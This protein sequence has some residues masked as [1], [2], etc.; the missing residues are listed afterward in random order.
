MAQQNG[1]NEEQ[2][3]FNEEGSKVYLSVYNRIP[4]VL[5][6]EESG[7]DATEVFEE[8]RE[9]CMYYKIYKKGKE[10]NVEGTN[11]DYVPARLRYKM[12]ATLINKEARFLF[13]EQP[14][15]TIE[16]KGDLEEFTEDT[17]RA[18]TIMNELVKTIL[19]KN[20]FQDILIKGAR[21]CFIGKRV[22]CLINFNEKDG[23]TLTFLPSTQF[24][25]EVRSTNH[26]VL[27]KF[28][29]F[30]V[31]KDSKTNSIK[32]IFKKKYTLENINGIDK[33]FL[34][35]EIYD[36]TAK[37][38]EKVMPKT[39]MIIDFIPAVI[40]INDGLS[41]E[42][43]GESEIESLMDFEEWYSKLGNADADAERKSMNPTKYL[44]DMANNSTKNLSTAA[45]ALWDLGSDQNLENKH[46]EVGL[47]EPQMHYSEALKTTLDRIKT[48]GYE[49]VDMPNITN[50]SLSGVI[51][52]GKALKAI[53]WPLIVRCKEK[54]KMWGP[55][56]SLMVEMIVKGAMVYPNTIKKYTN[57]ILVP[58]DHTV[59]VVQNTPLPEDE[60]E[61]KTIDLAEVEANTMSKKAYMKKWRGLTNSQV[62][63]E[64]N[65]I[66][67][68]RQI[69]EDASFSGTTSNGMNGDN[70]L[71]NGLNRDEFISAGKNA[72][73]RDGTQKQGSENNID[74]KNQMQQT[75]STMSKLNGTQIGSLISILGGYKA[76]N[77]TKGQAKHLIMSMGLDDT[78]AEALLEEEKLEVTPN[79]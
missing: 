46:V 37:L 11:G 32:R 45:G 59:E 6:R 9:I 76:G 8:I 3:T 30:T 72:L 47:L 56:L 57:D 34:E 22:A 28:V 25:Y 10:F 69:I 75:R 48:T 2:K 20:N 61:E 50:E 73:N 58:I 62:M 35:E 55:N 39:E 19:D 17:K 53:Y 31:M 16:Q 12:A 44:V 26:R 51:T 64:L 49:Q 4:Y 41:E 42:L 74:V 23:V 70:N 43:K 65:Q 36:G 38:I 21:D 52:S 15:I 18:L 13:A 5:I 24:L 14:D 78:F 7:E 29:S 68:E 79:V 77:F 60:I 71:I 27:E 66:A 1:Q 54:M 40:F 63:E 33:V 67:L